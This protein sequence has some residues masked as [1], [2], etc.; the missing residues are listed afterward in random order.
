MNH[1][2]GDESLN[3]AP[4]ADELL[5]GSKRTTPPNFA[6]FVPFHLMN[7]APAVPTVSRSQLPYARIPISPVRPIIQ[8]RHQ[9]S[10]IARCAP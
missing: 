6:T 8:T 4:V 2:A 9:P 5:F 3:T 10:A 1:L 7:S